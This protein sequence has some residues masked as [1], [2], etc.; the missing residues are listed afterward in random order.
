MSEPLSAL[1]LFGGCVYL[2]IGG[3]FLVRGALALSRR[4]SISPMVVGLTVVAIGTSA[5]E[6]IVSLHSALDGHPGISVGNVVGSNIANVL[7]VIGVPALIHPI[8]ATENTV[9]RQAAFMVAVSIVFV[10]MCFMG[11]IGQLQAWIMLAIL[12]LGVAMTIRGS[13]AMPGVDVDDAKEQMERVLGLPQRPLSI[14]A[15]IVLGGVFLPIGAELTVNGAVLLSAQL[16]VAEAVI[17]S[18]FVALGT[19]LP[20]L[21]STLIAAYRRSADMALG[22]VIGSN[23]LNIL[24][25][26]GVTALLVDLPVPEIYLRRELWIMLGSS[27]VLLF[28]IG[29]KIAVGRR[30]GA[31]FCIG[32]LAYCM[33]LI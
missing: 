5:P 9:T 20:E 23:V 16:G 7:L 29:R 18:T 15:L 11:E 14:A 32:Y 3:D 17:G 13:V 31:L 10:V 1:M 27:V 21:S 12:G 26:I 22:N 2:L 33:I 8:V 30:S 6:L 24:V 28:F 4:S 25:I 19:S